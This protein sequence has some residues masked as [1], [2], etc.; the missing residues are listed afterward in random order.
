[1]TN[2][3]QLGHL[4]QQECSLSRFQKPEIQNRVIGGAMLPLKTFGENAFLSPPVSGG[5]RRSVARG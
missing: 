1:M 3:H 2:Y 5:S 4:K